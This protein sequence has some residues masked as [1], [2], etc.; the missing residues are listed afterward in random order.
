MNSL[1]TLDAKPV[2]YVVGKEALKNSLKHLNK[3]SSAYILMDENTEKYCLNI[4]LK[5]RPELKIRG[6]IKIK[7]G[8][9]EKNLDT[10]ALIWEKLTKLD[11]KRDSVL[12]NL[13]GGVITDIG[14]FVAGTFKRGIS[15]VN[16][17]TTL[18]AQVDAAIGGK[19]GI[20][21]LSI[22]NQIG[23]ICD[24]DSVIIDPVFLNTLDEKYWQSGFA[25]IIKYALIMDNELWNILNMQ[26]YDEITN[27][28]K[29]IVRSAKDKIDIVRYDKLEKGIRK[30]LNFGHTVGLA[31][32][33]F[34]LKKGEQITHGQAI[35]AGMICE[36]WI[37]SKMTELHCEKLDEI[38][39]MF[40]KNFDRLQLNKDDIPEI[41][42]I[43]R[44]DKKIRDGMFRFSLLRRLGKAV[45]DI[46]VKS[47]LVEE[48]LNFYINRKKCN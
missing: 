40:D 17:P 7:S 46:V 24:P 29:I 22:K 2:Q 30:N 26:K 6:Y 13:G 44:Q 47:E 9:S 10:T 28:N 32:E 31:F 19:T 33:S 21:F 18:L 36:A 16:I 25:E 34:F 43:M 41:I 1:Y 14:G 3:Y 12:I 4:L 48:S 5:E 35:A 23:L 11:A 37:S 20:N 39:L 15:F 27:W 45:H 8:E 42:E 38:T